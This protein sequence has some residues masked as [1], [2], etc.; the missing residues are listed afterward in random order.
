MAALVSGEAGSKLHMRVCPPKR[1]YPRVYR[2]SR[3]FSSAEVSN[4]LGHK[5][6]RRAIMCD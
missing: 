3:W 1:Y 5:R 2:R 6:L 4:G